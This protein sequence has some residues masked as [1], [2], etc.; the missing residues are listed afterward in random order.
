MVHSK[1]VTFV[2][3]ILA[4]TVKNTRA[5]K[6]FLKAQSGIYVL[7][8]RIMAFRNIYVAFPVGNQIEAH[9]FYNMFI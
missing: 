2:E 4:F 1:A 6:L 9:F 7:D 5:N 8:F 3:V